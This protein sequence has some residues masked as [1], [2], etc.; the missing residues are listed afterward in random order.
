LE[1]ERDADLIVADEPEQMA[2]EI[3][4][5]LDVPEERVELERRA[6]GTAER[7]YGWDAIAERQRALYE[8]LMAANERE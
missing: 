7:V 1:L 5:L 8:E 2:R 3:E 4:R 6:R